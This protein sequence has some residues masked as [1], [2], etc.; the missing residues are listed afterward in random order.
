MIASPPVQPIFS[1]TSGTGSVITMWEEA[2]VSRLRSG[3]PAALAAGPIAS[4]PRGARTRAPVATV[5]STPS[6]A[7]RKRRTGED[8]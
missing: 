4:T 8:S 3:P 5:A 6:A 1:I 2:T 7:S